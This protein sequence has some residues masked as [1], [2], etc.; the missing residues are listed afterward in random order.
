MPGSRCWIQLPRSRNR[1]GF[2]FHV[3]RWN[4]TRS[5][6]AQWILKFYYRFS[7]CFC[8]TQV[9]T[10]SKTCT[11]LGRLSQWIAVAAAAPVAGLAAAAPV[12]D[13]NQPP[14]SLFPR[15]SRRYVPADRFDTC[16]CDRSL[17]RRVCSNV[18]WVADAPQWTVTNTVWQLQ[19]SSANYH[20]GDQLCAR[21]RQDAF[22]FQKDSF[23]ELYVHFLHHELSLKHIFSLSLSLS[24]FYF[25]ITL[26]ICIGSVI[27]KSKTNIAFN[28]I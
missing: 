2:R 25:Q 14:I 27:L 7:F 12:V 4:K 24:C 5:F 21:M 16:S 17:D 28:F 11:I 9:S 15:N 20:P 18:P 13:E 6:S 19:A 1:L 8:A 10:I 23:R 26:P 22:K 3:R